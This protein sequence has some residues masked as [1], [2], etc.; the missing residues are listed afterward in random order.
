MI[1]NILFYLHYFIL[2]IYGI[3]LS[4]NFSGVKLNKKNLLP[5]VLLIFS[6]GSAQ[7]LC[8]LLAGE[9]SVWMFYPFITH[10]P[11]LLLLSFYF[12]K[13]LSTAIVSLCS[14][15]L[16]CQPANWFGIVSYHIFQNTTIE[17]VVRI[18][19]LILSSLIIYRYVSSYISK[20][21]NKE[22]KSTFIFGIVPITYYV[23]DYSM[24]IYTNFW[25]AHAQIVIE[26]LPLFLCFVYLLFCIVYYKEYELRS[27]ANHN[28]QLL[29]ISIEQQNKEVDIMK[30]NERKIRLLRHDMRFILNN[31]AS[32]I[33]NNDKENALKLISSYM[34]EIEHTTVKRYCGNDTI[35]Y[36][37]SSYSN[38]CDN[39]SIQ[40]VTKIMIDEINVDEFLFSSIISNALDNAY[41]AQLN[42]PIQNRKIIIEMKYKNNKLLLSVK[43]PCNDEPIFVDGLPISNQPNH[44]YGTQSIRY[45]T[46]RLGGNC[47]FTLENQNFILRVII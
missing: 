31:L 1:E 37:L 27:E 36:I 11:T 19:V 21:F 38:K 33:E 46:K 47:Q 14:A 45:V 2:Y 13:R 32:S 42:V 25:D 39:A 18:A 20:I 44:G 12:R 5:I 26:F 30:S 7:I 40:F 15:Y 4:F 9:N 41:N 34:S 23:Y 43:N 29:R 17:L 22:S 35:N 28:E 10:L 6:C 16:C 24:S 8:Y 3:L